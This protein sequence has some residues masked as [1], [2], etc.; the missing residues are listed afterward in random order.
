MGLPI[1]SRR[2]LTAKSRSGAP[3]G[4]FASPVCTVRNIKLILAYDGTNY[5]G[6]QKQS[7]T[8]LPT[9]QDRLEEALAVLAHMPVP[10]VGAGRTDA[11]VHARGQ[12]VSFHTGD[13]TIPTDRIVPALNSVLPPD[14]A[15][16]AAEEAPPDFHARYSARAKTYTYTIYN[17]P[18]RSPFHRLYAYHLPYLLDER[19]MA[20]AARF[21]VG[22]HDFSSFQAAGRPVQ[23]A[24]RTLFTCDVVRD[25]H[26]VRLTVRG[27]GFLYKMVRAIAGTLI[28]VGCGRRRPEEV[29]EILAARDRSL[30]GPTAPPHGLCLESVEY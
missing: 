20:E 14:I 4:R 17:N 13:W 10:V 21:L 22:E 29:A 15:A 8:G 28:E 25:G 9:V 16:L 26:L 30:A 27:S 2:L 3:S 1:T 7:G 11:G 24:V 6:F 5:N 18:V 12:V 23:S 19:R